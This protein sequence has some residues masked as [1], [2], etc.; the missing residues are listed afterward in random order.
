MPKD[1]LLGVATTARLG[2]HPIHPMLVPFPIALLTATFVSDVAFWI[3][4]SPAF[5]EASLWLLG[6]ALVMGALAALAGFADFLGN[7]AIRA[8]PAAWHHMIGNIAA[9][10]LSLAS[11][12]VRLGTGAAAG[13]LP[14]GLLLSLLVVLILL[15]TGWKGG[16]LVYEHRIG[17]QPAA[18]AGMEPEHR[19][20][21]ADAR[22]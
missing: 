19:S 3:T 10:I 12:G 16:A 15:Y 5:A 4:A 21:P 8:I 11:F 17:V 20:T 6:A 2:S 18:S 9:V 22:R 14:W 13:V 1:P 7:P